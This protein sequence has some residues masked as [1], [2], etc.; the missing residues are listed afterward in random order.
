MVNGAST[1]HI[2]RTYC[3]EYETVEDMFDVSKVLV[4][5]S[6]RISKR[7]EVDYV[8]FDTDIDSKNSNEE[9]Y[10][11]ILDEK[12]IY[13]EILGFGG[14]F[15]DSA[16]ININMMNDSEITMKI[17]KGIHNRFSHATVKLPKYRLLILY[18]YL[19]TVVKYL[20]FDSSNFTLTV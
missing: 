11:Y 14:A 13:Q 3:D 17:I 6:D 16:G 1:V 8:D 18:T 10:D 12:Q 9:V 5:T 15:T 20:L 4:V 7:M 2:F 19:V